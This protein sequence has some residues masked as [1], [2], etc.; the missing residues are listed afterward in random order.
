MVDT[1]LVR[2]FINDEFGIWNDENIEIIFSRTSVFGKIIKIPF[3]KIVI[4]II[5]IISQY[6]FNINK[7]KNIRYEVCYDIIY[8]KNT[9]LLIYLVKSDKEFSNFFKKHI[10][11]IYGNVC[12]FGHTDMFDY[13]IK[14]YNFKVNTYPSLGNLFKII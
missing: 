2:E 10:G 7:Y 4:E 11:Y 3:S 14:N 6:G 13:M 8:H 12:Y 1:Q 5:E 9:E